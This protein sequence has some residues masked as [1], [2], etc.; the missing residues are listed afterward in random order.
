MRTTVLSLGARP[1][2]LVLHDVSWELY[3]SF[4]RDA[5]ERHLRLT[6]DNG[7]LEIMSPLP[8]H[9]RRKKVLGRMIE[10]LTEELDIPIR[11]FGSTTFRRKKLKKGAEPDECYYI[12]NEPAVRGRYDLDL[13]RDPPPDLA[14]EVD[15]R[16]RLVQKEPIYA[17]LGVPEIWRLEPKGLVSLWRTMGGEYESHDTSL[18]FPFLA[19][20]DVDRY[21]AKAAT[22]EEN[23]VIRAW[24][25]WIRQQLRS[26]TPRARKRT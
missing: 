25:E 22:S 2:H 16:E 26:R 7:T 23:A 4:L 8:K 19:M 18:A 1:Q 24:R 6:Y 17:A 10:A 11:S 15:D 14:V 3:T 12:E 20:S 5:E 13:K 9:E 21:L